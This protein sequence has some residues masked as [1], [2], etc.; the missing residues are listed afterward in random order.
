M[1]NAQNLLVKFNDVIIKPTILLIFSAG[2]LIFMWGL[3]QFMMNVENPTKREEG[4]THMVWGLV[5]MLIMCG[6][7]GIL[8]LLDNTFQLG[9]LNGTVDMTRIN[10][11]T[12]PP[13]F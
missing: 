8:A 1:Q 13:G 7:Y 2:F 3:V 9:A 10:N 4:K 5:G 12:T 11:V 6:V